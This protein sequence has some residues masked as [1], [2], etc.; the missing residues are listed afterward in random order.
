MGNKIKQPARGGWRQWRE[1]EARAELA[2]FRR[3]GMTAAGYARSRGVSVSRLVYWTKQLTPG[4]SDVAFVP[5][6]LPA[7]KSATLE[8]VVGD[9]VVRVGEASD[10]ERVARLVVAI[11]RGSAC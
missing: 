11:A 6:T 2:T 1:D 9:V 8:V 7:A 3:S 5:V 10:V 4:A